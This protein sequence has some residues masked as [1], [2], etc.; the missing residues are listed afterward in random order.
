MWGSGALSPIR[1]PPKQN[2]G[3]FCF[4]NCFEQPCDKSR[5]Y[6][7]HKCGQLAKIPDVC[8]FSQFLTSGDGKEKG[9][10]T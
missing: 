6:K 9:E 10:E 2:A 3:L 4:P 8:K 1:G 5:D 7:K